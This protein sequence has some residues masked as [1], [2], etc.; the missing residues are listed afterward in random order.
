[1][2]EQYQAQIASALTPAFA[3]DSSPEIAAEAIS[4][5]AEFISSNIVKDIEH[6]GRLLRILV[7]G[8]N[9]VAVGNML[10]SYLV[11]WLGDTILPSLGDLKVPSANAGLMLKLAILSA[12]AEI[13]IQ[14]TH[15]KY[16]VDIVEPHIN[17]LIPMWLAAL[18][19]YAKLHFEP[20]D[21]DGL[22]T[23]DILVDSEY[24]YAS[25]EF[26]VQVIYPPCF[27]AK[28]RH[29]TSAGSKLSKRLRL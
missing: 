3:A 15:Q 18:S 20:E 6:M 27:K 24:L 11:K 14:S 1:L 8:L 10:P 7:I 29:M 17:T 19:S 21:S 16:L 26:L 12:W 28:C 22:V 9:N 25:K 13:Q 4:I 2:L 23:E 5:C